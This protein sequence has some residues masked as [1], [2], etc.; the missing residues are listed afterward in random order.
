[1][2]STI[3][4]FADEYREHIESGIC[5]AGVCRAL[6]T[7]EIDAQACTGCLR[8]IKPCPSGAIS[9]ERKQP[10]KIDPEKCEKCGICLEECE[11]DAVI[12]K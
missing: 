7:Y 12:R 10:H 1:V 4:Y 6:V 9:G 11:F 8:C 2:L 3:K 5:R